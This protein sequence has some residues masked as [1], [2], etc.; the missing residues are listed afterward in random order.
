MTNVD[1]VSIKLAAY[2]N[3]IRKKS[4]L[5]FQYEMVIDDKKAISNTKKIL[6][7]NRSVF[8]FLNIDQC[9]KNLEDFGKGNIRI[10]TNLDSKLIGFLIT[11][12][13]STKH[14][15]MK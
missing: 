5:S 3:K 13:H 9:L 4:A 2:L 14:F 8:K 12:T 11:I 15:K 7:N 1:K 10:S 6:S